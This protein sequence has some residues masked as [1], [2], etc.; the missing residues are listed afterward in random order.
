VY[1]EAVSGVRADAKI[2]MSV[3]LRP[4]SAVNVE[5]SIKFA[6][7]INLTFKI[8]QLHTL[9]IESLSMNVGFS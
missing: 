9:Q 7:T 4:S 5:T 3:V 1:A 2:E 6:I 8:I